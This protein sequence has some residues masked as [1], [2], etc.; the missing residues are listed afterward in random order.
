VIRIV[1]RIDRIDRSADGSLVAYD[2]KTGR[3]PSLKDMDEG[4]D[5]QLGIYLA[6]IDGLFART[7]ETAVGGAYLTLRDE[8]NRITNLLADADT[9]LGLALFGKKRNRLS[10]SDFHAARERIASNIRNAVE[11][12]EDGDFRV[13]PSEYGRTCAYCDYS[14]VC[15]IEPYRIRRKRRKD[16]VPS[17]PPLPKPRREGEL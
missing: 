16:G 8:A 2:Y 15:R 11:R 1:G 6:A 14:S 13:A 3:G 10:H 9:P 5:F 4:R 7:D 12:I 17:V